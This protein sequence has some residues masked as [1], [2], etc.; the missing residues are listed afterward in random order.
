MSFDTFLLLTTIFFIASII[1]GITILALVYGGD[2]SN[3]VAFKVVCLLCMILFIIGI[4]ATLGGAKS[5]ERAQTLEPK[6]PYCEAA[7]IGEVPSISLNIGEHV[8]NYYRCPDCNVNFKVEMWAPIVEIG[9][10]VDYE[11]ISE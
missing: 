4:T 10:I 8:W 2:E 11:P 3:I 6:C 1:L 9:R 7:L 5:Y